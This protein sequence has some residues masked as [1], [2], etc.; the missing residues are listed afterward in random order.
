MQILGE[1]DAFIDMMEKIS[2]MA[3]TNRPVFIYG[4]RGSGKELVAQRIHMLSNRCFEEM[5]TFNC[6]AFAQEL[7]A[8]ELFGHE[9]GAFTG[10]TQQKKGKVECAHAS[11]LFMDEIANSSSAFQE[12]M[13]RVIEYG[14]IQRVGGSEVL[15]VDVR[16]IA[17]TNED[18]RRL[19]QENRF[20]ADLLDRLSFGVIVVPP[21]R[22]R[23]GDISILAHNFGNRMLND[24]AQDDMVEFSD[25]ALEQLEQ[26][27]WPG[28]IRELKNVIER[29]VF[30]NQGPQISQVHI[31]P[32]ADVNGGSITELPQSMAETSPVT[33]VVA[34]SSSSLQKEL[35]DQPNKH[36]MASMESENFNEAVQ[37]LKVKMIRSALLKCGFHQTEAAKTLGMT[38]PQ[39]RGHMKQLK[40]ELHLEELKL[41]LAHSGRE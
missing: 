9:K 2:L 8:S 32:W 39:L 10:A 28:N 14:Q 15:E 33:Q 1:S 24:M 3:K 29:T 25:L 30:I 38:Y 41:G 5:I 17:A 37:K 34:K 16:F 27:D 23:K 22:E 12:Q 20:R 4:E 31:D 18:P 40:S 19:I 21:L 36:K 11:T 35:A 6:G 7:I 13:L 26:H